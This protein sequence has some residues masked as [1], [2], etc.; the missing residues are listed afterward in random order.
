MKVLVSGHNGY[1]GSALIPLLLD[2]GH[3]VVGLDT[4]LFGDAMKR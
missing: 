4:F 3:E 2:G 1:I